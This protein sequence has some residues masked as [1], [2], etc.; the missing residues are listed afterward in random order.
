MFNFND[1]YKKYINLDHRID[2]KN[3]IEEQLKKH[4]IHA[5]RFRGYYP[6]ECIFDP[7]KH[8][9]IKKCGLFGKLG[10]MT[11]HIKLMEEINTSKKDGFIME[12]DLIFCS[13]FNLRIKEIEQFL[14][15]HEW[16]V[17]WLCSTLHIN[18]PVCH[19]GQHHEWPNSTL[20]I[21]AEPTDNERIIK[22]YGCFS[23]TAYIVNNKSLDKI[24]YMLNKYMHELD[25]IDKLFIRIEPYLNTYAYI[26]GCIKQVDNHSDIIKTHQN[27]SYFRILGEYWWQD[28]R[29]DFDPKKIMWPNNY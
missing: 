8:S 15:T 28:R 12:D 22:T 4:N 5:D 13:D 17:F 2:R 14:N 24:L 26:P 29:E 18:P 23:T 27:F 21:D 7:I 6:D 9:P 25:A 10:C 11:S 20:G 3:Y 1:C 19:T 16:D